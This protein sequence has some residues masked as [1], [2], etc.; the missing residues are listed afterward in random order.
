ML[1]VGDIEVDES[2]I[3]E[4]MRISGKKEPKAAILA[5][6]RDYTRPRSQK[7]VIQF[8]GTSDGFYTDEE[9]RLDRERDM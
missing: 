9:L 3:Q 6:L 1:N 2:V 5:A 7:E 4:A 8:L